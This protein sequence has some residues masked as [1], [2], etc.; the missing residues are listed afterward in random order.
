MGEGKLFKDKKE[1]ILLKPGLFGKYLSKIGFQ[2]IL[3]DKIMIL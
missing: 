2:T 1:E 3:N